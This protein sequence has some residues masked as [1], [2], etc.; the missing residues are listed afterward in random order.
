M[1]YMAIYPC[2]NFIRWPADTAPNLH[3]MREST[4]AHPFVD[5]CLPK[6]G[7]FRYLFQVHK[8]NFHRFHLINW[9]QC[10][11]TQ[12][13]VGSKSGGVGSIF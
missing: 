4:F 2:L 6:P 12:L 11:F 7:C 9:V 3:W 8:I 10:W 5:S 13:N 1:S